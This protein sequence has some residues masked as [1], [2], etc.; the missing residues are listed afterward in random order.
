MITGCVTGRLD[1]HL[2]VLG[3]LEGGAHA[4]Q[5]GEERAHRVAAARRLERGRRRAG[6]LHGLL[7]QGALPGAARVEGDARGDDLALVAVAEGVEGRAVHGGGAQPALT[8]DA[9]RGG[10][11]LRGEALLELLG[12]LAV[13]GEQQDAAGIDAARHQLGDPADEGLGLA[14]AGGREHARRAAPVLDGGALGGV[15]PHVVGSGRTARRGRARRRAGGRSPD[16]A[17]GAAR[18]AWSAAARGAAYAQQGA[19]VFEVQTGGVGV[20]EGAAREHARAANGK[21]MQ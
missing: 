17:R 1:A 7:H 21:P 5:R 2:H 16:V 3:R 15:E 9:P 14:G 12:R 20:A 8:A 4:R 13:E 11:A 19:D 6:G 10:D 18:P